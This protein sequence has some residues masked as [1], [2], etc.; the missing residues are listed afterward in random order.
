MGRCGAF[1]SFEFLLRV[2][3][4]LGPLNLAFY[5][6]RSHPVLCCAAVCAVITAWLTVDVWPFRV[7]RRPDSASETNLASNP[8]RIFSRPQ[9]RSSAREF[10]WPAVAGARAMREETSHAE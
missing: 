2:V 4:L 5:T 9:T 8:S 3:L 10:R 7:N 6:L 1:F